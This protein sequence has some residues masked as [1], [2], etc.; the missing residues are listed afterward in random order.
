[1]NLFKQGDK[2]GR[3]PSRYYC[4][5]SHL[6]PLDYYFGIDCFK[7]NVWLDNVE[8]YVGTGI[9]VSDIRNIQLPLGKNERKE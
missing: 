1:L 7:R 5:Q 3:N 4:A 8:P 6:R 2:Y 9:D